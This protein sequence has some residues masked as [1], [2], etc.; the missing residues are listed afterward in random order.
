MFVSKK[1]YNEALTDAKA[2]KEISYK[3]IC[4]IENLEKSLEHAIKFKEN[5]NKYAE[6]MQ[7]K[8]C[9]LVTEKF[10]TDKVIEQLEE[11]NNNL[12]QEQLKNEETIKKLQE[13]LEKHKNTV[14]HLG[15][16]Y[17]SMN[18][19]LWCNDESK[20]QLRNLAGN[21]LEADKINKT[22]IARYLEEIAMRVGGGE[23]LEYV[24]LKEYLDKIKN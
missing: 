11:A 19:K 5:A 9:K 4:T 12:H 24:G 13:E 8:N 14:E 7:L 17:N 18:R 10:R 21:I 22:D 2:Y 23:E 6:N 20:R 16:V 3:R 1:K 15:K